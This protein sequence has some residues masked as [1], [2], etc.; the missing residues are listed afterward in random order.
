[1]KRQKNLFDRITSY[2]NLVLAHH[3][4]RK[5]KS[6]YRE[7]KYVNANQKELLL[8]L[9]E[10]LIN[11]TFTTSKYQIEEIFDGRKNRTIYK[12]PYYPDRI[13]QH[14]LTNVCENFWIKSYIRDTFQSIPSRGTND[15]RKR[16]KQAIKNQHNQYA[17]KFDIEKYYPNVNNDI[18][19][20]IVRKKIK[21]KNTLWLIDN[22]IDSS[23]GIPIGN[24]T[25]QHF[26]NLYLT[27]FD[28]WVKQKLKVK[29]YYRY[30]D[31][32][33]VIGSSSNYCHNIKKEMFKK[34]NE[35][36]NLTIKKNWQ[37]FSIDDRGLDFV[38][39]GFKP[40]Q[41]KLRSSIAKKFKN[42]SKTI[43]LTHK[44][45]SRPQI[46]SGYMSYWGWIKHCNAKSLWK[47]ETDSRM[48]KIFNNLNLKRNTLA[49]TAL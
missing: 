2:E 25:S 42:K 29:K 12:L 41:I 40:T 44:T 6:H 39:Y 19:K 14:A 18:L 23:K 24:Y 46:V 20:K 28:W 33:I 43:K 17:L 36:Y 38:G 31:D 27:E 48:V 45:M 1:M 8:K 5:G 16:V 9:Q 47:K 30:C 37:V 21:C 26:G 7:V 11:K 49:R 3:Q 13:V 34:L 15:A 35:E 4:A 32:I 22:I 10:S